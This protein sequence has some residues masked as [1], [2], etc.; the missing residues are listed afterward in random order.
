[1]ALVSETGLM[2]TGVSRNPVHGFPEMAVNSS[3]I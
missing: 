3:L 2:E 1:M